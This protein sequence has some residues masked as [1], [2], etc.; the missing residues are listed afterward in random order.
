[1]LNETIEHTYAYAPEFTPA[2]LG[3]ENEIHPKRWETLSRAG[4]QVALSELVRY[5][6]VIKDKEN[7]NA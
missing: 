3:L 5:Y 2:Q 1:M 6:T 4:K 7:E